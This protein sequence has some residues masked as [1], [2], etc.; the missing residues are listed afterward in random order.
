MGV[1]K[2][3]F[4]ALDNIPSD[5]T[6]D[7]VSN[8]TNFKITLAD[9][10]AALG[11]TG[12]LSQLGD[13]LGTPILNVA[14]TDNQIRNLE[15]GSGINVSVSPN[16]GALIKH[17]FTAGIGGVPILTN[18]TADSPTI[19]SIAAG[20]G[21]T[22]GAQNGSIVI[23][24]TDVA[25]GSNIVVINSPDDFPDAVAGVR[26][27]GPNL[28]Y[29]VSGNV[30]MG[31]D[32]FMLLDGTSMSGNSTFVDKITSA[33]TGVL[34]EGADGAS[35][36]I[37]TLSISCIN[38]TPISQTSTTPQTGVV[39]LDTV[40][41]EVCDK[42][43][44]FNNTQIVTLSRVSIGDA[45]TSGFIVSGT[46]VAVNLDSMLISG[47]SGTLLDFTT[48]VCD[49][50]DIENITV[51]SDTG[52]NVVIDGL[53]NSGN[54]SAGGHGSLRA[55]NIIGPFTSTGNI[56]PSDLRWDFQLNNVF[57]DSE[58]SSYL[59]MPVNTTATTITTVNTP[60]KVAGTW[61]DINASRFTNDTTG[62]MTYIGTRTIL[63]QV[64]YTGTIQKSGGGTDNFT[65]H[66]A[67]NGVPDANL[68]AVFATDSTRD[69]N[70]AITGIIQLE[71]G[72]FLEM[73]IENNSDSDNCTIR[74]ANFVAVE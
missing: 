36:S 49:V 20:D 42:L 56:L 59:S 68:I 25:I 8:G 11:V 5:A 72:D 9:F 54:I 63:A 69:P 43:G 28:I 50:I 55:L 64:S 24:A 61:T 44:S 37:E 30:D 40:I 7:F 12:T 22:V 19:R 4:T 45:L 47:F 51:F 46:V 70:I 29:R 65:M 31:S 15:P 41:I 58:N 10:L 71:T 34:F 2:S 67:K 38:G 60:V 32:R 6:L 35:V 48:S 23:S 21:V 74:G 3:N 33:T 62:K 53:P 1:K 18:I 13:P 14:G 73:F 57:P 66:V 17:N 16:L 26:T 27:L 39:S 52:A